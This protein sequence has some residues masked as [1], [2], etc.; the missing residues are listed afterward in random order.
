VGLLVVVVRAGLGLGG[1]V[2][3]LLGLADL[4]DE[5]LELLLL[6]LRF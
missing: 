5:V 2:L 4:L 6:A 3:L 1:L